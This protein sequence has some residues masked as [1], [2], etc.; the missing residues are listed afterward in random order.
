M[1]V[2]A[3]VCPKCHHVHLDIIMEVGEWRPSC[4]ASINK[5]VVCGCKWP[6]SMRDWI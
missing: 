5:F 2:F 4:A 3:K 6:Q 1:N